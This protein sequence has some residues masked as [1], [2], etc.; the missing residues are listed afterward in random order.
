MELFDQIISNSSWEK[1]L[2]K[3]LTNDRYEHTLRVAKTA[4]EL[5]LCHQADPRKAAIAGYLHDCAKNFTDKKLLKSAEKYHM[6]ISNAEEKNTDL[7]HARVGAY[8]ARD[9]YHEEDS[10]VFNAISYH[11]T[12]RPSMSLLEKI[13]YVSDY[14][15]P[16]RKHRGRLDEIRVLAE[17]DLN[18]AV[19]YIL[20]DT[21]TYLGKKS[22][23]KD[24]RTKEAYHYY[25]DL[26]NQG[27]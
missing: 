17:T 9:Q 25:K 18:K 20:E 15:E 27:N 26:E 24:P 14:I 22:K 19:L 12:G 2:K 7:L 10:D 11:T 6:S 21:L 5:A 1:R 4:Y 3:N 23:T 8:I 16:G 13:L